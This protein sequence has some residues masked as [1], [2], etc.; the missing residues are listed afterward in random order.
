MLDSVRGGHLAFFEAFELQL[1]RQMFRNAK[2]KR[3]ME[4]KVQSQ[5]N[6]TL[7]K[8]YLLISYKDRKSG[9][10]KVF[11]IRDSIPEREIEAARRDLGNTTY[12]K[13]Q[14]NYQRYAYWLTFGGKL[15]EAKKAHL[16]SLEINNKQPE[17]RFSKTTYDNSVAVLTAIAG[18]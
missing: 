4:L 15:R 10:W 9:A 14:F 7:T 3:L 5:G 6:T 18:E 1:N 8:R 16:A 13:D 11:D 12:T 17:A 2:M